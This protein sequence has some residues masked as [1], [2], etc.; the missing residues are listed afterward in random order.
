[1]CLALSTTM[2][3]A[4]QSHNLG[5]L[6]SQWSRPISLVLQQTAATMEEF[7]ESVEAAE[8]KAEAM[9]MTNP[10]EFANLIT[11]LYVKETYDE[12]SFI[13]EINFARGPAAVALRSIF[14]NV[15]IH[16]GGV[17]MCSG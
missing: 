6:Q 8:I 9:K 1:M 12:Q 11:H 14:Q 13:I 4:P 17:V 15:V 2:R 10:A 5:S 7:K 3:A 16:D